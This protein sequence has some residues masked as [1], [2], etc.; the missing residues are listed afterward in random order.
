MTLLLFLIEFEITET[1]T[2]FDIEK[3]KS[4]LNAL[5]EFGF[6]L[7]MDDF[8]TG[9]S[10]LS[11]LKELPID[12]LKIDQSFVRNMFNSLEDKAIVQTIVQVAQIMGL[13][14]VAEGVETE[15]HAEVLKEMGCQILQGYLYSPPKQLALFPKSL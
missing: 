14:V 3:L 8:G 4:V 15:Q 9:Y 7:S 5:K 10:S 2:H 6:K 13:Q 1:A 12:T 11:Q